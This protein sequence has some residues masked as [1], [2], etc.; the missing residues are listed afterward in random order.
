MESNDRQTDLAFL[1][2]DSRVIYTLSNGSKVMPML[3][4]AYC[5]SKCFGSDLFT[6]FLWF[7][8]NPKNVKVRQDWTCKI[9]HSYY[10]S[11]FQQKRPFCH[12]TYE[13]LW[14]RSAWIALCAPGEL[15][16]GLLQMECSRVAC[17][18]WTSALSTVQTNIIT[19][20]PIQTYAHT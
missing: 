19:A 15:L 12:Y 20:S 11:W 17:H 2:S 8:Q 4:L 10:K 9:Y 18:S 6:P 3:S 16:F 7:W 1:S 14:S 13:R 5:V